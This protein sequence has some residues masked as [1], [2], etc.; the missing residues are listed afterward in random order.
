MEC[1]FDGC[2]AEGT[3]IIMDTTCGE[4]CLCDDHFKEIIISGEKSFSIEY[5]AP[6]KKKD[7]GCLGFE[8]FNGESTEHDC[9]YEFSGEMGCE[10]CIHGSCGGIL[11]PEVNPYLDGDEE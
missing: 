5:K 7:L 2:K 4:I 3:Q 9:E 11:D 8:D 6:E 10:E 1:Q